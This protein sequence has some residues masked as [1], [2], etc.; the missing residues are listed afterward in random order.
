MSR[1]AAVIVRFDP[2]HHHLLIY[3]H[4]S[5][6]PNTTKIVPPSCHPLRESTTS[7]FFNLS[8]ERRW[9][10]PLAF[11]FPNPVPEGTRV[12]RWVLL[13]IPVSSIVGA[14]VNT[15]LKL[16][17]PLHRVPITGVPRR[18][19][20]SAVSCSTSG[21]T[22]CVFSLTNYSSDIVEVFPGELIDIPVA[23][24]TTTSARTIAPTYSFVPGHTSLSLS[25]LP[26]PTLPS[27]ASSGVTLNPSSFAGGV[28]TVAAIAGVIL[29]LFLD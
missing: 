22:L 14:F 5:V 9:I 21:I 11:R 12:P 6:G 13:E 8:P 23:L 28:T 15:L 2:L 27:L 3:L 1:K 20:M 19:D 16:L 26:V 4:D 7:L 10:S 18:P 17:S 24:P 25:P 29:S